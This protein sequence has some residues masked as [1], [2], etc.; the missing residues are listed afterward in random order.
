MRVQITARH[1][2]VSDQLRERTEELARKLQKFEPRLSAA[3]IVFEEERHQRNV[4]GILSVDR[5]DPVV[6]HGEG[7]DFSG[8]LDQL[9]DRL[10][11]ILRR[12]RSQ[13]RDHQA[14]SMAGELGTE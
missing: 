14:R 5:A 12:R 1:C 6:A 10:S 2:H 8:A 7:D 4:E 3:E 11:K 13:V 9:M